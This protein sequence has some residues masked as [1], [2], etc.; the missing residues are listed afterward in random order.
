MRDPSVVDDV[1]NDAVREP[2]ASSS[3]E[4]LVIARQIDNKFA[5]VPSI[6]GEDGEDDVSSDAVRE[7][8]GASVPT[9]SSPREGISSSGAGLDPVVF[10]R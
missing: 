6:D 8:S 7:Q 2:S 5:S 9:T 4:S 10:I 1:S 3:G